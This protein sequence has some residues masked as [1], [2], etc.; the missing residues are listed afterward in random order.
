MDADKA[1]SNLLS[2]VKRLEEHLSK[3]TTPTGL[4]IA[5]IQAKGQNVETLQAKF[6]E[7]IH[8][9]EVKMLEA[10]IENLRSEIKDHQEAVRTASAN[11]DGTIARWKV[12][13]LKNEISEPKAS[14]LVE[15]AESF[16]LR[17]TKDIAVSRAS[18]ALR[19]KI[20]RKAPKSESMDDNE[21]FM[22]TEESIKDIVRSEVLHAM[23]TVK[24]PE[25]NPKVSIV[26]KK[27]DGKRSGK[28]RQSRPP[29]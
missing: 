28:H 15:A 7:I 2:R 13:L 17:I 12:K 3:D 20:N 22:P 16:V 6:D 8:E 27:P 10:T 14:S 11:I 21:V 1:H 24:P 23:A 18:K 25:R 4:R 9:A 19:T 5:S 29:N 26:R